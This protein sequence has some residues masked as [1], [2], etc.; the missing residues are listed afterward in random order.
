[1][2]GLADLRDHR[3]VLDEETVHHREHGGGQDLDALDLFVTADP[4]AR[5]VGVR[6]D[7]GGRRGR[8][9]EVVQLVSDDHAADPVLR[10]HLR[11]QEAETGLG[12]EAARTIGHRAVHLGGHEL[13]QDHQVEL[14]QALAG[15]AHHPDGVDHAVDQAQDVGGQNPRVLILHLRQIEEAQF[16]WTRAG[17][18]DLV[19][20]RRHGD[21]VLADDVAH[22]EGRSAGERA[23][24]LP[25]VVLLEHAAVEGRPCEFGVDAE[26]EHVEVAVLAVGDEAGA[27]ATA[28][29]HLLVVRDTGHEVRRRSDAREAL[30][31]VGRGDRPQLADR[32]LRDQARVGA[33]RRAAV[34]HHRGVLAPAATG[35]DATR[36]DRVL[37]E[38]AG[39]GDTVGEE[40]EAVVPRA[41]REAQRRLDLGG[42]GDEALTDHGCARLRVGPETRLGADARGGVHGGQDAGG[43]AGEVDD[44]LELA[45]SQL[46]LSTRLLA[47]GGTRRIDV[48]HGDSGHERLHDGEE[49]SEERGEGGDLRRPREG[50]RRSLSRL[51]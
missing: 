40:A 32:H 39:G 22:P 46:T 2:V 7:V 51:A 28:T 42:V 24:Q 34:G 41:I 8:S 17:P 36:L 33:R 19:A 31:E 49:G 35:R 16:A 47:A 38:Q 20:R 26:I 11:A 3:D 21:T 48:E 14:A 29:A 30:L 15:L 9:A 5:V 4:D 18:L 50:Q 43:V 12:D 37:P 45:Q 27:T 1:M 6:V 10:E 23:L 13:R 44:A 25:D